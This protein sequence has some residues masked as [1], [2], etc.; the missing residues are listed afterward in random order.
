MDLLFFLRY[1]C[2]IRAMKSLRNLYRIGRGPS[3]SHTMGPARAATYLKEKYPDAISVDVTLYGSLAWTGK[4]HLTDKVIIE[5]FAPI[6]VMVVF[7]Y[8]T[9]TDF[10]NT[11][12]VTLHFETKEYVTKRVLSLGGGAISISG[13]PEEVEP[14]VYPEAN[15][16][17]ISKFCKD[18]NMDLADYV[19]H[20]EGKQIWSFFQEIWD[21]MC[22]SIDNGLHAEGLLPGKLKVQRRA[23]SFMTPSHLKESSFSRSN[24]TIDAYAFAV[25]EENAAGGIIATAPT[26]GS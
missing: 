7:D 8:K 17:E 4:G 14:E 13:E 21:A 24:R 2:I 9:R 23:K 5:T 26:C 22:K 16:D 10:P 25:N 20:Y 15:F 18:N 11:F 6:P 19:E 3:S 12:D 1:M